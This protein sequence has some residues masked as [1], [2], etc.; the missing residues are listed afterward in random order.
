[1]ET[2]PVFINGRLQVQWVRFDRSLF[3]ATN[4]SPAEVWLAAKASRQIKQHVS[5]APRDPPTKQASAFHLPAP[6]GPAA[7]DDR[8]ALNFQ[9]AYSVGYG[10]LP[11]F[12]RQVGPPWWFQ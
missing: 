7:P 4:E 10:S 12:V 2:L 6:N 5:A 1:M 3:V 8:Q 11:A 9:G